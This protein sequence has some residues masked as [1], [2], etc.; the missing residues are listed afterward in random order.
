MVHNRNLEI[1]L[2]LNDNVCRVEIYHNDSSDWV[3]FH[4]D[5]RDAAAYGDML[6]RAK[7]ELAGWFEDMLEHERDMR[8]PAEH[9][10]AVTGKALRV[11]PFCMNGI[12]SRG[13]QVALMDVLYDSDEPC[14]WCGDYNDEMY[15]IKFKEA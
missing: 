15:S 14:E 2:E 3:S 6:D 9:N 7:S 8:H 12:E 11:C 10:N 4:A 5:M 1:N 13:E